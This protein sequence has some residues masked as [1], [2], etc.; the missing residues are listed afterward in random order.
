MGVSPEHLQHRS[1]LIS[2]RFHIVE[3]STCIT[4]SV[5]QFPNPGVVREVGSH[6]GQPL[7]ARI[8]HNNRIIWIR[9]LDIEG[10][11]IAFKQRQTAK[12]ARCPMCQNQVGDFKPRVAYAWGGEGNSST[13]GLRGAQRTCVPKGGG[14]GA[15]YVLLPD[16]FSPICQIRTPSLSPSAPRRRNRGDRLPSHERSECERVGAE[17]KKTHKLCPF[18][19]RAEKDKSGQ[20]SLSRNDRTQ[21]NSFGWLY[22]AINLV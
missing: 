22:L 11:E 8:L 14:C 5:A 18:P 1:N 10:H 19:P 7:L 15:Q 2:S 4:A 12:G 9:I 20:M 3:E 6:P 13:G 21:A 17:N 16:A